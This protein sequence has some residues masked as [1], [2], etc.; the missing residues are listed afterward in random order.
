MSVGPKT[1]T[2]HAIEPRDDSP[3]IAPEPSRAGSNIAGPSSLTGAVVAAAQ[4]GH[5]ADAHQPLPALDQSSIDDHASTL[6]KEEGSYH[7]APIGT[8]YN[9]EIWFPNTERTY[10]APS[11]FRPLNDVKP[12]H[13]EMVSL[14]MAAPWL[15]K[16]AVRDV[17]RISCYV[18]RGL[19]PGYLPIRVLRSD[20]WKDCISYD[21]SELVD[22]P[23]N[24]PDN[25]RRA[26][27]TATIRHLLSYASS[28]T[29]PEH[30]QLD[31][32][33]A[34]SYQEYCYAENLA[35]TT[36]DNLQQWTGNHTSHSTA[37]LFT[38]SLLPQEFRYVRRAQVDTS[39]Q[40]ARVERSNRIRFKFMVPYQHHEFRYLNQQ[41][42]ETRF[43]QLK[44]HWERFEVPRGLNVELPYILTLLG[45]ALHSNS[46]SGWWVVFWSEWAARVAASLLWDAFDNF[47][48]WKIQPHVIHMM[49]QLELSGV[50][51]GPENAELLERILQVI[52]NTDWPLVPASHCVPE[53]ND[54]HPGPTG[55]GGDFVYYDIMQQ[56]QLSVGEARERVLQ[57]ANRKIPHDQP[58]GYLKITVAQMRA[59]QELIN[60]N[61]VPHPAQISTVQSET[62]ACEESTGGEHPPA[63]APTSHSGNASQLGDIGQ[64]AAPV[65]QN[66]PAP[67]ETPAPLNDCPSHPPPPPN[68]NNSNDD[69]LHAI[70]RY[71]TD[72]GFHV[73]DVDALQNREQA[74]GFLKGHAP[75]K[76]RR[77][78]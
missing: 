40:N 26:Y 31:V 34:R 6:P 78:D 51:A 2:P 52:E 72:S 50:L 43:V 71:L 67:T 36:R 61:L 25:A 53:P 64:S 58:R 14:L 27:I 35:L 15:D 76:R 45:S 17:D 44:P 75:A 55:P 9:A 4:T 66:D 37:L 56:K 77:I 23:A 57:M 5:A 32:W 18:R 12:R 48:I 7:D 68:P 59:F 49:R 42:R 20:I 8:D 22:S 24:A 74:I 41:A 16:K 19:L 29:L 13:D 39:F 69:D 30:W 3:P 11:S 10:P 46:R 21:S 1:P 65:A 38:E 28:Y 60:N 70:R 73:E 63:P 33:A 54:P 47:R 62:S